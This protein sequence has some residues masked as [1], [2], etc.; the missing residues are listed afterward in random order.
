VPGV[1]TILI[2]P[3]GLFSEGLR[4][5][6]SGTSFEPK[7]VVRTSDGVP[8]NLSNSEHELFFIIG[9]R[10]S[11]N[12]VKEVEAIARKFQLAR[13]VVIGDRI[14][15]KDVILALQAGA[16]GY[17]NDNMSSEVLV[18]ALELVMLDETVLPAQFAKDLI[19]QLAQQRAVPACGSPCSH[20]PETET[21]VQQNPALSS[22]ETAILKRL[23][24][25]SSNKAIAY[26]MAITEATVKVHVKSILRKIRA[27]NRTQAAIWA[28]TNL[29][30]APDMPEEATPKALNGANGS[31]HDV[32]APS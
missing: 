8:A 21:K 29:S 2:H 17:L 32:H 27:R 10:D 25:G 23:M 24:L 19:R 3:N 15:A 11:P 13:I 18:K 30:D 6:L 20:T 28:V 7:Q 12:A 31:A 26:K 4:R 22:R 5:I 16:R 9:G 1:T 14:E